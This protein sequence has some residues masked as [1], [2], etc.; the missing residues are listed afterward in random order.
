[1]LAHR[2]FASAIVM[3]ACLSALSACKTTHVQRSDETFD[4]IVAAPMFSND[5]PRVLFDDGHNNFHRSDGRYA[6]FVTLV[7]NDGFAVT[8]NTAPF[9]TAS[10]EGYDI[11]VIANALG[12]EPGTPAFAAEEVEALG[13]WVER[14]GALLLVADHSPFGLAAD[15]MAQRSAGCRC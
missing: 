13:A 2:P 12:P 10:L 7:R 6:P 3:A 15:A 5:G 1:M 4:A 9:S 8:S 14:G 11:L